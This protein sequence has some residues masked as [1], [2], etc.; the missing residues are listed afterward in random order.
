MDQ[1]AVQ[2]RFAALATS[3]ERPR[4]AR[5]REVFDHV[6]AAL[7]AG[8]SR[9]RA[10]DE[11]ASLGLDLSLNT[12]NVYYARIKRERPGRPP[13][14]GTALSQSGSLPPAPVMDPGKTSLQNGEL[15]KSPENKKLFI[16]RST[17]PEQRGLPADWRTC[18]LT[19]KQARLLTREE[20]TERR[21]ARDKLFHPSPYDSETFQTLEK[22]RRQD[23]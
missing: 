22:N 10:R 11:L 12:F 5:F 14:T 18:K 13:A 6:A 3:D 17:T 4:M 7:N 21:L 16:D 15:Q 23:T 9:S 2:K 19:S 8:V 1:Q 20:K